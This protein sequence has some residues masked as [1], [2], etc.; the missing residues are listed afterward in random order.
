[1]FEHFC[2][3]FRLIDFLNYSLCFFGGRIG[4]VRVARLWGGGPDVSC[5]IVYTREYSTGL[6]LCLVTCNLATC[7]PNAFFQLTGVL[8]IFS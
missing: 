1:V 3:V 2:L 7:L 5:R 6:P 4:A 8:Y